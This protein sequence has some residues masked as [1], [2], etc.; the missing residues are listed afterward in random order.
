M[1][2][3]L[4]ARPPAPP[5]PPARP[6]PAPAPQADVTLE[7]QQKINT[8]SRLNAKLHEV[9]ALL[10]AKKVRSASGAPELSRRCTLVLAGTGEG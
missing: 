3:C 1:A 10:A 4:P 6:H 9:Q 8:F 2:R 5:A 7:D